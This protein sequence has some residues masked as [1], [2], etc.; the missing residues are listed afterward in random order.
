M[1]ERIENVLLAD[2]EKDKLVAEKAT[3]IQVLETKVA[4]LSE[5]N[6]MNQMN[7][8]KAKMSTCMEDNHAVQKVNEVSTVQIQQLRVENA[9]LQENLQQEV[10]NGSKALVS[11]NSNAKATHLNNVKMELTTLRQAKVQ[12]EGTMREHEQTTAKNLK[13]A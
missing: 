7:K 11:G 5:T 1:S 13:T 6:V 8:L 4:S 2:Q 10:Q 12:W 3:A 9:Q